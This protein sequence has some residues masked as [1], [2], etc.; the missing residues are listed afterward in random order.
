MILENQEINYQE[1]N[2]NEDNCTATG[3]T[4]TFTSGYMREVSPLVQKGWQCPV[5]SFVWA[6][7]VKGCERCNGYWTAPY[8]P[9]TP[10]VPVP[11]WPTQPT[12]CTINERGAGPFSDPS[13]GSL[14][15]TPIS[16]CGTQVCPD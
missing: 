4:S 5:C 7:S 13:N 12:W 2:E 1:S 10:Y 9:Y 3:C 14:T 15:I 11:T 16:F 6:P 8:I